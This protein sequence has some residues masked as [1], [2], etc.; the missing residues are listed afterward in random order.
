M[1]HDRQKPQEHRVQ[2]R[3]GDHRATSPDPVGQLPTQR[4]AD[5]R[6]DAERQHDRR[7]PGLLDPDAARRQRRQ[8]DEGGERPDHVEERRQQRRHDAW[9]RQHRQTLAQRAMLA[10]DARGQQG[11]DRNRRKHAERGDEQIGA[12][13]A[14]EPR[15]QPADRRAQGHGQRGPPDNHGN[16]PGSMCRLG[17]RHRRRLGGGGV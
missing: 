12:A 14:D 1:R 15:D 13:P 11:K 16:G 4:I 3:C 17:H 2:H 5:R 8:I 10:P 6:T 7:E 9:Q